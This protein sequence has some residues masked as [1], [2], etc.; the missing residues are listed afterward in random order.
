M[1]LV[2]KV[3]KGISFGLC[4]LASLLPINASA[5]SKI[6]I[7]DFYIEPEVVY[8]HKLAKTTTEL[9]LELDELK[10]IKGTIELWG[11]DWK[12]GELYSYKIGETTFQING[13][14]LIP[15]R[16]YNFKISGTIKPS[17]YLPQTMHTYDGIFQR[18]HMRVSPLLIDKSNKNNPDYLHFNNVQ[19]MWDWVGIKDM[20]PTDVNG[21]NCVNVADL[22]H[23]R[24]N[25][26]N[27]GS[28]IIPPEV[29]VNQDGVVNIVDLLKVRNDLGEGCN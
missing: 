16:K 27:Y 18:N 11:D 1:S 17:D 2:E 6:N 23:V 21:D 3:V 15:G 13:S 26:G 10:H 7:R 4:G 29:D 25:L 14:K 28:A 8:E 19:H 20:P 12:F 5:E 9:E 24:A 22:L